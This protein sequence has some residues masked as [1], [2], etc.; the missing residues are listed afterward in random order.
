MP[1]REIISEELKNIYKCKV[2]IAVS[3]FKHVV[4][5]I[6]ILPRKPI[7]SGKSLILIIYRKS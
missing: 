1:S 4:V 2:R 3:L 6:P 5:A 7:L